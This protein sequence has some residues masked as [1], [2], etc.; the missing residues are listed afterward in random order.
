MDPII[1]NLSAEEPVH[2]MASLCMECFKEGNTRLMLTKIPY[3]KEIIISSFKCEFCFN[4]N[5]S[6]QAASALSDQG[7]RFTLDVQTPDDL[8]RQVIK[9]E[10][11]CITIPEIELE[12]PR[13]A[14]KGSSSTVEGFL[15]KTK[16]G[17]MMQQERRSSE[18]PELAQQI[19]QFLARLDSLLDLTVPF[20]FIL[21]DPSGNSFVEN[22]SAPAADPQL[23]SEH[24]VR[25]TEDEDLLGITHVREANAAEDAERGT[26]TQNEHSEVISFPAMCNACGK[27]AEC[28]MKEVNI[29]F[30][31]N[32]ILMANVCSHCGFKDSEVKTAGGIA[33]KGQKVTLNMTDSEM[34]LNRDILKSE[35]AHL[36]IPELELAMTSGSLG[37]RFTTIEGLLEQIKDQLNGISNPFGFGDSA[38]QSGKSKMNAL[39]QRLDDITSGKLLTTII[40]DDPAGNSYIQNLYAPDDDPNLIVEHYT[41]TDE[42]DDDLGIKQMKTENY[43][44]TAGL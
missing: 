27:D 21:E 34:D 42:D 14:Q 30:F 18:L 39:V 15:S 13:E 44:E 24:Y 25:S 7:C 28:N 8:N 10:W 23:K 6:V 32:I 19:D 4:S 9:S 29:P 43:G 16:E 1:V 33:E 41:R 22:P 26:V 5:N 40:V 12:I 2:E 11:A 31:K 36:E 38:T 37:G 20:T 35:T 3:F 17:L